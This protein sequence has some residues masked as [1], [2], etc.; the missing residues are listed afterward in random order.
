MILRLTLVLGVAGASSACFHC[1]AE[2]YVLFRR[3]DLCAHPTVAAAYA[4]TLRI[5]GFE[6]R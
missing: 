5:A 4:D 6:L 1:R 3:D 2:V